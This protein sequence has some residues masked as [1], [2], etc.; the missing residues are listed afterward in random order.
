[1]VDITH[2]FI[3]KKPE[4]KSVNP[5]QMLTPNVR[6]AI[7]QAFVRID[8]QLKQSLCSSN[9]ID[10]KTNDLDLASVN[11]EQA[12]LSLNNIQ[13]LITS[14]GDVFTI[15]K[16]AGIQAAKQTSNL[17]PLCH[18]VGKIYFKIS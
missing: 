10:W 14:K 8:D 15:S 5:V 17:L 12:D 3:N 6:S 4:K 11:S 1:M 9:F 2:K 7:A 13:E 18:Q 16:L